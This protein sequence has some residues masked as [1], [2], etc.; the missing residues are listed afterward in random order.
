MRLAASIAASRIC[1][2][3]GRADLCRRGQAQA[4][5]SPKRRRSSGPSRARCPAG[6]GRREA[7]AVRWASPSRLESWHRCR[8][9][10]SSSSPLSRV[11]R[12]CT[13]PAR[14]SPDRAR[15]RNRSSSA[16]R[17]AS[18]SAIS[19]CDARSC[20]AM[21]AVRPS[22]AAPAVISR[23]RAV[24]TH[25]S[26]PSRSRLALAISA[27]PQPGRRSRCGSPSAPR[28]RESSARSLLGRCPASASDRRRPRSRARFGSVWQGYAP[29]HLV[30]DFVGLPGLC[31]E[32]L[33]LPSNS[34]ACSIAVGSASRSVSAMR[35]ALSSAW[36]KS[37]SNTPMSVRAASAARSSAAPCSPASGSPGVQIGGN[38]AKAWPPGRQVPSGRRHDARARGSSPRSAA[39]KQRGCPAATRARSAW[40][41]PIG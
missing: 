35:R 32:I 16:A 19:R 40:R 20:S 24:R 14:S 41:L 7:A 3:L 34:P 27:S 33:D 4:P 39:T 15:S 9:D 2:T 31:G 10:N 13:W 1:S 29:M 17:P 12:V 26:R 25:R 5:A 30:N 21:R 18:R 22:S 37:A 38:G 23:L 36:G 8:L 6:R 28:D 11:R